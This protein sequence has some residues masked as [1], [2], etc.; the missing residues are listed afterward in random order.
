MEIQEVIIIGA[1][2]AGCATALALAQ[3]HIPVMLFTSPTDE[4]IYHAPFIKKEELEKK[5]SLANLS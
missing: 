4:R 1:G 2:I 5:L 3:R